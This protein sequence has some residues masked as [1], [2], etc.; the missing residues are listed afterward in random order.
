MLEAWQISVTHPKIVRHSHR[1]TFMHVYCHERELTIVI[2]VLLSANRGERFF[3]F[4]TYFP[5]NSR[6][7]ID[8][9]ANQT[10]DAAKM[11]ADKSGLT[12]LLQVLNSMHDIPILTDICD[13]SLD[14]W[15]GNGSRAADF[16]TRQITGDDPHP[17]ASGAWNL[18]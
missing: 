9:V 13:H 14:N 18:V 3:S 17:A 7:T 16:G 1:G 12:R 5:P 6:A 4:F 10:H 15:N 11:M 8:Y 2:V